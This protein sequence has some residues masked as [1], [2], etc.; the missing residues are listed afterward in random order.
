MSSSTGVLLVNLGTPDS[1]NPRD[2]Y[3]YLI[4][5]LTDPRVIDSPWIIRQFLVRGVIVPFRYRRS[6][7]SYQQI[8]TKEGSP[9]MVHT[10]QAKNLLQTLLGPSFHVEM[11][12]RYQNP[13]IQ[14]GI[15]TLMQKRIDHLVVIPLFPQYASAT[16][17]SV[18]QK[19]MEVLKHKMII[20]KVTMID[21]YATHP[22]LIQAFCKVGRQYHPESYDHILFSFHSLPQRHVKKADRYNRCLQ[23][24]NCCQ[25]RCKENQS[26]YTA[27]CHA[28]AYAIAKEL[29][30]SQKNTS[31]CFQS[32]LGNDPWLQPY[33]SHTI[34]KLAK[35]GKKRV[36]VFCPSFVCDCLETI[37][38]I[39]VEYAAEFKHAGG[40]TLD[41][42]KGLNS[43]PAWIETLKSLVMQNKQVSASA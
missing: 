6:A 19:V 32:R 5:F 25:T 20:P 7:L 30:L 23:D 40:E 17:G 8:W 14:Q 26:C 15:D 27:Q 28:T 10:R 22:D 3:R 34:Q 41:L 4:E 11:A 42:V 21:E 12:M 18:Q 2:V 29:N 38:E 16:T 37:F 43:E 13:S 33:T 31:I 9:L 1:P 35:E 39:G 36:L 24:S